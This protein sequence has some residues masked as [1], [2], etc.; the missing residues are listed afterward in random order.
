[1]MAGNSNLDALT[2]HAATQGENQ[3]EKQ[4]TA[5]EAAKQQEPCFMMPKDMALANTFCSASKYE[6]AGTSQTGAGF[7]KGVGK[8][9]TIFIVAAQVPKDQLDY[10][11]L[12]GM[13]QAAM[14][15]M[16]YPRQTPSSL[17]N[18]LKRLSPLASPSLLPSSQ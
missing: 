5:H 13:S 8:C 11:Q 12:S 7:N 9:Y 18:R 10:S 1:M 17:L 15:V 4:G 16:I 6:R 14:P 2:A 3:S